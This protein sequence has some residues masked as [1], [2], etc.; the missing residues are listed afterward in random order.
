[1][2]AMRRDRAVGF[3][4]FLAVASLVLALAGGT[5]RSTMPAASGGGRNGVGTM[6]PHAAVPAGRVAARPFGDRRFPHRRDDRRRFFP[7]VAGVPYDDWYWDDR[8]YGDPYASDT[9]PRGRQH[10]GYCDVSPH[11]Y[12]QNCV[13]KEGP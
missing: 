12:P 1:M 4:I 5:A 2:F 9:S 3:P 13:W 8:D 6:H 11:S 7:Y 10:S